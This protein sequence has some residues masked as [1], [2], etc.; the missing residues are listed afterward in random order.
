MHKQGGY[1]HELCTYPHGGGGGSSTFNLPDLRN[2]WAVGAGTW[3]V[4]ADVAEALPTIT[5]TLA[6]LTGTS[7]NGGRLYAAWGGTGAL[8]QSL[9]TGTAFN[10]C[11]ITAG[12]SSYRTMAATEHHIDTIKFDAHDSNAIYNRGNHVTPASV[13]LTPCIVYE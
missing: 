11:N 13:A 2:V 8:V 4:L 7:D 12:N 10:V 5:G 6:A 9:H 3:A 1:S